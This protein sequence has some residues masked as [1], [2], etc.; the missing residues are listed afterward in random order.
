[1][2]PAQTK[3]V[4]ERELNAP[5]EDVFEWIDLQ[6][7]LGSASISQVSFLL[8]P[9]RRSHASAVTLAVKPSSRPHCTH[10]HSKPGSGQ[11]I[12][13]ALHFKH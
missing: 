7:P 5:L 3:E 13:N 12:Q 11:I 6:K 9:I 4:I 1:M 8:L 2:P 10:D